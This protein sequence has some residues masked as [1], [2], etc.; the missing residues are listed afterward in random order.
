MCVCVW[1]VLRAAFSERGIHG[2]VAMFERGPY[3]PFGGIE[4]HLFGFVW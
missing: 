3:I 2:V 1:G 4:H